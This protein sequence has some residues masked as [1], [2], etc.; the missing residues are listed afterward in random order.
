MYMYH[1]VVLDCKKVLNEM[2]ERRWWC[3][4]I[5]KIEF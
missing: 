4:N 5:P 3:G 1:E 2:V